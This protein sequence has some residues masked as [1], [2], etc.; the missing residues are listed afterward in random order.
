MTRLISAAFASALLL[1]LSARADDCFETLARTRNFTLGLPRH[2]VPLPD[3]GHVLY[4]RSGPR[5]T[6]LRL[7]DYDV[8]SHR[9]RELAAPAAA[10][11]HLSVEEKARRERARMTLTGITD[12]AVSDDGHVVL[13]TQ[14]DR[15]AT[16]A[17]PQ[18]TEAPVQGQGWIAPRLSP[19]GTAIAAVRDHDLHVIELGSG[20]DTAL[21]HGGAETLT[22]GTA[23]FAA[24]EEL[25]RADGAWWSPD[26]QRLVF[27][28]ADSSGVEQHYIAD[29]AHPEAAPTAFRYPRAG[30]ANARTRFGVI[31]R[32]GGPVT[33]IG[34]DQTVWPY[35]A[36]VTWPKGGPLTLVVLNR[37]QTREAV[38]AVDAATG[39][40]RTLLTESDPAWLDL[41]P[42]EEAQGRALPA[43]LPDGSGFL[44]AAERDGGW[45]LELRHAD[46]TL[47]HAVTPRGWPFV[48]LD[49]VDAEAGRVVVT[50]SPDRLSLGVF[51]VRLAG[52][53]PTALADSPGLH[54][55]SFAETGHA[56]FADR[57]TLADGHA[58]TMLRDAGGGVLAEL[59]SQAEAPPR[60]PDVRYLTVGPRSLDA[61]VIRPAGFQPG[62]SYPV[63][64]S[65]YAGPTIK[66]VQR[67]PRLSLEDQCLADH[68]F[69]VVSLDGRGTPGRGRDFERATKGNFIDIPLADQI[70]GLQALGRMFPEMDMGRVGVA[71]WSFGGYF[72]AMATIRRPDVFAA[73]VAGAPVVDFADYDTAYTERYL[74]TPRDDPSGYRASNVLTYAAGLSRPLMIVHGLTDDNVYFENSFKLTQALLAY[75]KPYRLLLLPGTHQL[76]DPVLRARVDEARAAFLREALGR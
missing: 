28:E 7:F 64:L 54:A 17:L 14:A 59:P 29:P 49:D 61:D 58:G 74:G 12:F 15:L 43:W 34:L 71:G 23:E 55:A 4:L 33:W 53:T 20:R 26:S 65:V 62:R 2:A 67:A 18:G 52:G 70:E 45:Q 21:T 13:V 16:V 38:L 46:G 19:D 57:I 37:A 41:V 73:G 69:I 6:R 25:D 56:L 66:V 24:A 39:A 9:E 32:G 60:L 40:T 3:G 35:V 51:A 72:T 11:E 8:S 48:S 5:D 75:G 47:D 30:T 68:G 27:E 22:H 36:R 76:P 42:R 63:V 10:P 31:A 1:G 44:W 50:G